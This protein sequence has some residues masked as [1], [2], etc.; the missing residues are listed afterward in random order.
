MEAISVLTAAAG[1]VLKAIEKS[2]T[3][4]KAKESLLSAFWQWIRPLFLVD[5]PKEEEVIKTLLEKIKEE[6][7][8]KELQSK[9]E[10]LQKAGV[11]E[12]NIVKQDLL[13]VK[14]I[15]IGDKEYH[16]NETYSRKNIVEGKISDADEFTLG[17]GH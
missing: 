2:K 17:D 7:F 13:R 9:V 10:E 5:E 3:A 14:K 16:P 4:E 11:K 6:D 8:F 12:K 1:Y 15:K